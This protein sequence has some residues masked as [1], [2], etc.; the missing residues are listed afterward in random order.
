MKL[1]IGIYLI[2][3]ILVGYKL[4]EHY[5]KEVE[6]NFEKLVEI[7]HN[8]H[9]EISKEHIIWLY[10]R[11]YKI[12]YVFFTIFWPILPFYMLNNRNDDKL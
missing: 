12:S 8:K 9:P 7:S 10:S 4:K 1:V 5:T 11:L 6:E 2:G 3:M